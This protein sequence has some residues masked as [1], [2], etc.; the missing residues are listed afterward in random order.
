MTDI[1]VPVLFILAAV[2]A[3]VWAVVGRANDEHWK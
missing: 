2:L 3:I 1:I